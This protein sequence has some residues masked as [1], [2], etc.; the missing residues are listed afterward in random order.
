[1]CFRLD[2]H[3]VNLTA[4][5]VDFDVKINTEPTDAVPPSGIKPGINYINNSTV[6]L[7]LFAPEKEFV[8]LIGDFNDWLVDDAFYMN[9]YAPSPDST[10]WWITLDNLVAG[11]EYAFQYLI[12]G[13]I[14]VADPYTEKVSIR[15][16]FIPTVTYPNLETLSRRKNRRTGFGD[17]NGATRINPVHSDTFQRPPQDELVIYELLLRI[18]SSATI[19]KR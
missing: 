17:P 2:R 6:T 12:D 14:R 9:R 5:T 7:A 18:L 3:R 11:Q 15:N 10:L 1:M 8:Y 13:S 16:D 4:D 19:T